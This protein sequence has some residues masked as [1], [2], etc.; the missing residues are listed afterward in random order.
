MAE[1]DESI[2][3]QLG[4]ATKKPTFKW[5]SY[6]MRNITKVKIIVSDK[7]YDEIKGIEKVQETIIKAFGDYALEIYGL[8]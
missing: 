7:I 4:K 3:S 1:K 6:L 8:S 5:A 2:L